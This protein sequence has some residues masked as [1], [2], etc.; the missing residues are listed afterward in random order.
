MSYKRACDAGIREMPESKNQH[1]QHIES[2]L[3]K[4][5]LKSLSL[6]ISALV[7]LRKRRSIAISRRSLPYMVRWTVFSCGQIQG[8]SLTQTGSPFARIFAITLWRKCRRKIS[9]ERWFRSTGSQ[10]FGWSTSPS[11]FVF[12]WGKWNDFVVFLYYCVSMPRTK[13]G[14]PRVQTSGLIENKYWSNIE[15]R[16]LLI[17]KPFGTEM[18]FW[19][20]SCVI[21]VGDP[22]W[23]PILIPRTFILQGEDMCF[24]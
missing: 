1:T 14:F 8:E 22:S 6:S 20:V 23:I 10:Q 11:I 5:G 19:Y 9:S 12:N 3:A 7:I 4:A 16:S 21:H 24:F 15:C 17:N 13:R 2:I 18:N